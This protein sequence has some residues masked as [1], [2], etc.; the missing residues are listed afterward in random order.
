M[1]PTQAQAACPPDHQAQAVGARASRTPRKSCPAPPCRRSSPQPSPPRHRGLNTS[2]TIRGQ[3]P[4]PPSGAKLLP[5][6]RGRRGGG[7]PM[8]CRRTAGQPAFTM[9]EASILRR[10]REARMEAEVDG[11]NTTEAS[12]V[13]LPFRIPLEG[14]QLMSICPPATSVNNGSSSS[15]RLSA[16]SLPSITNILESSAIRSVVVVRLPL[17][18]IHGRLCTAGRLRWRRDMLAEFPPAPPTSGG[19]VCSL[20]TSGEH[21]R[22]HKGRGG[23]RRGYSYSKLNKSGVR[24]IPRFDQYE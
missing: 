22:G 14:R 3:T 11:N 8:H 2:P 1:S 5:R 15:P 21:P 16:L 12:E 17:P 7:A 23:E 6:W 9:P 4:P 10:G 18:A 24:G 19:G 20:P 13:P